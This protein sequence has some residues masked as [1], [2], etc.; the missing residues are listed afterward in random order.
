MKDLIKPDN[1][2]EAQALH[3]LL[4]QHGIDA[5][6]VS[7]HDTAYDGIFQVR[8]GW[9]VI[10]VAEA[11]FAEAR[12]IVREWKEASPSEVPWRDEPS[13]RD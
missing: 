2:A 7:F 11:D 9:G 5:V 3:A 4:R 8:Y 6:V 10:R 1:A 13:G 12:R